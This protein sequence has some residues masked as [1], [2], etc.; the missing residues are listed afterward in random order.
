MLFSRE[1]VSN[2]INQNFEPA[3]EMVRPVPIVRIDFGN[4][5]VS[6]RTLHG[7]VATYVCHKDGQVMDILPGIYTP[8]E[9]RS[10]LAAPRALAVEL[11]ATAPAARLT[12]VR[13]Y[14]RGRAQR[15]RPPP[16]VG[17]PNG[18]FPARRADVGKGAFEIPVELAVVRGAV[19]APVAPVARPR[20]AAELAT[21]APLVTDTQINENQRRLQIHDHLTTADAVRPEQIKRWLYRDVLHADLDDPYLGLGED[22][23]DT[24]E[25]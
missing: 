1:D 24:L 10:A 23:L 17:G 2:F 19:I 20:T 13:N 22:F 15:L 9:F 4:D 16:R 6:T 25:R 14:H 7:N 18:Q 11:A 3:W 8:A 21:W 5:R 12:A